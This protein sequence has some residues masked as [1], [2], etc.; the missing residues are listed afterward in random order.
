M[1]AIKK[2]EVLTPLKGICDT[3]GKGEGLLN[4]KGPTKEGPEAGK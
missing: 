1:P 4:L 3:N 2:E